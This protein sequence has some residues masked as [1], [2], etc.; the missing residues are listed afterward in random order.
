METSNSPITQENFSLER[1][2]AAY[3]P[4]PG[5]FGYAYGSRK[6]TKM[7]EFCQMTKMTNEVIDGYMKI[8][9]RRLDHESVEDFKIR[10]KFQ[11][12]LLRFRSSIY[13]YSV[14]N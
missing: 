8:P 5:L 3:N 6:R 13:D 1:L 4:Q 7:M 9:P 12:D 14:Y 10:G 11:K 2:Y